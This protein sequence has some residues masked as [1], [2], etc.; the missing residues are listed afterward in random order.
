MFSQPKARLWSSIISDKIGVYGVIY[1]VSEFAGM[2]FLREKHII[3]ESFIHES[4]TESG[5]CSERRPY[6]RDQ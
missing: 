6:F 4:A 5:R 3:H 1:R 2:L